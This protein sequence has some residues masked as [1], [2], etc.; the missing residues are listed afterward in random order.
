MKKLLVILTVLFT[1]GLFAQETL[2]KIAAVVDNEIIL[3]SEVE[4]QVQYLAAQQNLSSTDES[5]R[6]MVINKLVE[7]KLMYAQAEIDSIEVTDKEVDMQLEN[8]INYMV[9][10][11]G[12]KERFEQAYGMSIEKIRRKLKD[13]NRKNMMAQRIKQQKFG[14]VEVTKIEVEEFYTT[15]KDSL[16][17]IPEKFHISHIFVNPKVSEKVKLEA[18]KLA[19]S[20]RDSLLS[21]ADFEAMA[22]KYSDDPGSKQLGGDLG[23]HKRGNFV[24]EYETAAFALSD[25][26]ISK[27]V[28]SQFGF[29]IIQLLERRGDAIHTRHILIKIPA[30]DDA[31]LKAIEFLSSIRD[32][33]V[34][35]ENTFEYFAKKYS[36]DEESKKFGGKL[37]TFDANQL[38][39]ALKDQ[40][41]QLKSGEISFPKRLEVNKNVYGFHILFLEERIP[42]HMPTLERDYNEIKGIAEYHKSQ[43]LFDEWIAKIKNEIYW[44]IKI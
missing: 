31:D 19:E 17:Q 2:D 9:N 27:V 7:D 26:D 34:R 18:K 25:G 22:K 23:F 44:E 12:S 11:F 6:K 36:D 38:D 20:I 24:T 32:S 5:L 10:Q 41:Y 8:Q 14:R 33:I 21:G 4:F 3:L 37:G 40:V 13:D 43:K 30:D 1:A 16:G 28:E 15:Y 42:A 29:H 39:K 35:K